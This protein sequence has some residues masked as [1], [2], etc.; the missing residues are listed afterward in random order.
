LK[1]SCSDFRT[2]CATVKFVKAK[3]LTPNPKT[4]TPL[5]WNCFWLHSAS[6]SNTF[7]A[8]FREFGFFVVSFGVQCAARE[9]A[10][11]HR[12]FEEL[13]YA[14]QSHCSTLTAVSNLKQFSSA[15]STFKPEMFT[16][17]DS[18]SQSYTLDF[19]AEGAVWRNRF[20]LNNINACW[21]LLLVHRQYLNY[22]SMY[23]F[24]QLLGHKALSH[25]QSVRF[26]VKL[27][28]CVSQVFRFHSVIEVRWTLKTAVISRGSAPPQASVNIFPGGREPLRALTWNAFEQESVSSEV[29]I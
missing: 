11:T 22:H 1:T 18:L 27:R 21:F 13:E 7:A 9:T 14:V 23:Q 29:L 8:G 15:G 26:R 20:P 19:A 2:T 4:E 5:L 10:F 17:V 25:L 16:A 6:W 12:S 3:L 28:R 24:Y